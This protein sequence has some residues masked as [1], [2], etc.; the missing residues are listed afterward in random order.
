MRERFFTATSTAGALLVND[1]YEPPPGRRGPQRGHVDRALIGRIQALV[2]PV[3][4][5]VT[6]A[7]AAGPE[8]HWP[9][10]VRR[11]L[12][13][14]RSA[15]QDWFGRAARFVQDGDHADT[16][17]RDLPEPPDF[18]TARAALPEPQA[19]RLEAHEALYRLLGREL[20]A[21]LDTLLPPAPA[22]GAMQP[23]RQD[24]VLAG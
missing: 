18:T 21:I 5:I 6:D 17:Q 16:L 11:S 20:R 14:H 12:D 4:L 23:G 15:M 3:S 2:V 7:G 1:R 9:G 13:A 22:A 8:G 24:L 19:R 10:E